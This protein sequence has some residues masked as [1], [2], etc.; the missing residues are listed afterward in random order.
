MGFLPVSS[1]EKEFPEADFS[2]KGTTI[3]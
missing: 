3:R 1:N 2:T